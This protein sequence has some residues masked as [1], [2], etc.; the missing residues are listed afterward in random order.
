MKGPSDRSAKTAVNATQPAVAQRRAAKVAAAIVA[1][2]THGID[3]TFSA[4]PL[5][6]VWSQAALHDPSQGLTGLGRR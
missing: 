4:K 5:G 1:S 2:A 3:A 6:R